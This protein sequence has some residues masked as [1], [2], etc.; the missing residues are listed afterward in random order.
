[1]DGGKSE[2]P[3]ERPQDSDLGV[4]AVPRDAAVARLLPRAED[5]RRLPQPAQSLVMQLTA[6][7]ERL[8]AELAAARA[9]AEALAARA[10]QDALTGLANRRG[11]ERALARTLSYVQRYSATAALLYLDLDGF[12][13]IN[14]RRG[15]A[16]GDAVLKAVAATLVGHVRASDQVARLGGDEF[17]LMLWNIGPEDAERKARAIEA[18]VAALPEGQDDSGQSELGASV[19]VTMISG[20]D[21]PA[22]AEARADRAMYVRKTA[23]K[24]GR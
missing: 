6:E 10:E 24:A 5:A 2:Q 3:K 18:M 1:M 4:G 12:K 14:D 22:V 17:A 19:G 20:D 21:T 23:R 16:A 9:E 8:E 11:F 7:V 13:A 15:H